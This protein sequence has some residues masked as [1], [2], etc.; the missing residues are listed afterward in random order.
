MTWRPTVRARLP[1]G[2]APR[3]APVRRPGNWGFTRTQLYRWVRASLLPVVDPGVEGAPL[4]VRMT[5]KVRSRFRPEVP[6][7]FVSVATATRCLGVTRQTIWNRVRA[8][9]MES[10]HV[11]HGRQRGL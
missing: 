9:R 8:G 2:P 6:E 11:T 7:G 1:T 10:C 3:S 5:N 4:R